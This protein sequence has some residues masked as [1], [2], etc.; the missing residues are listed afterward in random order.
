MVNKLTLPNITTV[1]PNVALLIF[2]YGIGNVFQFKAL[3][4]T[5][6]SMFVILFS[7]RA[8]FTIAASTL[9]LHEGLGLSQWIGALFIFVGVVLVTLKN[10]GFSIKS[11][12][13]LP[14]AAAAFFGFANTNDKILLTNM[15]LFPYL[16][17]AFTLPAV[18]ISIIF[19]TS[20]RKMT[21]FSTG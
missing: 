19:P 10:N 5:Q 18:F 3:K 1:L 14:L 12:E 13:W 6:A 4:V 15:D 21:T 20:A 16:I 9:F 17:M 2:L 11:K 7:T 8:L